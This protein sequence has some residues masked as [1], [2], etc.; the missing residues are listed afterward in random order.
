MRVIP[1]ID[2]IEGKCVRLTK[3]NYNT[4]KVYSVNPLEQAK[5]FEADGF[6]YLHLVDLDGAKSN[7]IVNHDVLE[8]ICTQTR[9]KVDFGG[10]LKSDED[11]RIALESGANQV[12][13]GSISVSKP[14]LFLDWLRTYGGQKIILGADHLNGVVATSAWMHTSDLD[15]ID[16]IKQYEAKG[17]YYT[18]C[19]D[20]SKDGMLGGVSTE[21]Y[22]QI[23]QQ[24]NVKL[25]ASGGVSSLRDLLLLKEVGCEG[26]I[27]GKAIYEGR[28]SMSELQSLC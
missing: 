4:Q 12:T 20:V 3:G 22:A 1:A 18:V 15:V 14:E 21:V 28:I 24:T 6:E 26:V 19:T 10:G 27:V 16:F 17:V 8:K 23:T 7:H 11:L 25:I 9:L 13:A 5:S 2:V